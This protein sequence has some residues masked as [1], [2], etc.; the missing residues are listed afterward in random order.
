[1]SMTRMLASRALARTARPT[2]VAVAAR[3]GQRAVAIRFMSQSAAK[4]ADEAA[5]TETNEVSGP[6][7]P[8]SPITACRY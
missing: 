5:W 7:N 4:A 8:D 3:Q 6:W 2:A 1:M